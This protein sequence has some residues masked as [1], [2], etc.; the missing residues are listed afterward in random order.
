MLGKLFGSKLVYRQRIH[1]GDHVKH[2][3]WMYFNK[4]F[5][6]WAISK[7]IG[8]ATAFTLNTVPVTHLDSPWP[9]NP[10]LKWAHMGKHIPMNLTCF[11]SLAPTPAPTKA[12]PSPTPAPTKATPSPTPAPTTQ[13]PS[14]QPTSAPTPAP[15]KATPSPTPAPTT[16]APS[17]QPTMYPV[18]APTLY[19]TLPP[20]QNPTAPTPAPTPSPTPRT[21]KPTPHRCPSGTYHYKKLLAGHISLYRELC[22]QCPIS[23]YT[24]TA[25]Q[26]SCDYCPA[27]KFSKWTTA[28]AKCP[29]GRFS[30]KWSRAYCEVDA[31]L[32]KFHKDVV[33]FVEV[34]MVMPVFIDVKAL[35]KSE[36]GEAAFVKAAC[37]AIMTEMRLTKSQMT[38]PLTVGHIQWQG[39]VFR[40]SSPNQFKAYVKLKVNT[41]DVDMVNDGVKAIT[42]S[43]AMK[44][45]LKK[46]GI[47]SPS[48]P[49][50]LDSKVV[51]PIIPKD[52][53]LPTPAP[54]EPPTPPPTHVLPPYIAPPTGPP[55]WAPGACTDTPGWQ[56]GFTTGYTCAQYASSLY[57][58]NSA[59]VPGFN[60]T[61]GRRYNFPEKNCVA[62]GKCATPTFSPT[63]AKTTAAPTQAPT[64][65]TIAPTPSP[66]ETPT[67]NPSAAPTPTGL[68]PAFPVDP[69]ADPTMSPTLHPT[70]SPTRQ[71][72][73]SPTPNPTISPTPSPTATPT[74]HPTPAC[75][76][77]YFRP[78]GDSISV[79]CEACEVGQYSTGYN[80]GACVGC[81]YGKYAT[82][83]SVACS[84]CP[85]GRFHVST[86]ASCISCAVGRYSDYLGAVTCKHCL[87]GSYQSHSG[88]EKCDACPMNKWTA[89]LVGR[90]SCSII[91]TPSPTPMPTPFGFKPK[92]EVQRMAD[93]AKSAAVFGLAPA[94]FAVFLFRNRKKM[95]SRKRYV[96]QQEFDD[97]FLASRGAVLNNGVDFE[98]QPIIMQEY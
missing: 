93:D 25:G 86:G 12:T 34:V 24:S 26:M 96:A 37:G 66:T 71:P 44:L 40:Q 90:G 17:A 73:P 3:Y 83:G 1:E 79:I 89:G 97:A 35:L 18:L 75:Q 91:P 10:Q 67:P 81:A 77:G 92:T 27:G 4:Q 38:E 80:W 51:L 11:V 29:R 84:S 59:V 16:Q 47:S 78:M 88:V 19:P 39:L 13:A 62:C 9:D 85:L 52:A 5:Q 94:A 60:W 31:Q 54:T 53:V 43:T 32:E 58:A 68:W 95:P 6:M 28:C 69:T 46:V 2:G 33:P 74:T 65:P 8:E 48:P 61:S 64:P 23:K 41:F 49:Y 87:S 15:T 63:P 42:F 56:Q 82:I 21:A 76:P 20:T 22:L 7:F 30:P 50:V 72:S 14:A 55:T 57:C 98:A 70:P 45:A 36:D